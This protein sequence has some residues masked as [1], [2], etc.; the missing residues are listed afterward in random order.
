M[1]GQLVA[2]TIERLRGEVVKREVQIEVISSRRLPAQSTGNACG[3]FASGASI[4]DP[5][6]WKRLDETYG[7]ITKAPEFHKV[8]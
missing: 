3:G 2:E 1:A 8:S 5:Y 4:A 7:M 6:C